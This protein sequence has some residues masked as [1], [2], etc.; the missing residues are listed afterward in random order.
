MC[1]NAS[2]A[3]PAEVLKD[4]FNADIDSSRLEQVYFKSAFSLPS[5]PLIKADNPGQFSFLQ[6]GLIPFWT[7]NRDGAK[8]IRYKTL[9]ARFET[10]NIKPS[11][12]DPADSK[13][14]AVVV[15]GYFEWQEIDGIKQPYHLYIPGKKPFLLA[16]IWDRWT[17][18]ETGE[19]FETFSIVT[20][21]AKGTARR[22]HN[23]KKRM[24]FILDSSN[25]QLW[26]D[27]TKSFGKIKS[28][29]DPD[30]KNLLAHRVSKLLT[31]KKQNT[32]TPDVQKKLEK[33]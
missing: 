16:G 4:I 8:G 13:R 28:K 1:F 32:N 5:W 30:Y 10:L 31:S 26:M 7:K 17:D 15:D 2:L 25:L 29:M 18:D 12:R 11:Y 3:Q 22:V 9:N 24:P 14:C 6:W 20:T 27:Q 33:E 19:L 23:I 21:E